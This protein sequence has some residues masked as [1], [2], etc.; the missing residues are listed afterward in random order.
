MRARIAIARSFASSNA[1]TI[2]DPDNPQL[3]VGLVS[4]SDRASQGVYVDQGLPGLR[5]WFTAA[6][7]SPWRFETRLIPDEQPQIERTLVELVDEVGCHLVLTTGGTGPAPRDVTPEATL[8]VAD[9]VL[10]GFGEQMRQVSLRYVPTAILSRQVGV[11][12]GRALIL[13]LPGQPKAIKETLDGVFPAVPYCIDLIGGPYV[14]THEAVCKAFR[15]K[16]AQ[17]PKG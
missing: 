7:A 3:V 14:E 5:E 12:R 1:S 6:L 10:P 17:R 13:N 8:A 15:P 16:S 9:K 11:V 4:I 2:V